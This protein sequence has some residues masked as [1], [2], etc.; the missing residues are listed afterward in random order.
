MVSFLMLIF[1]ICIHCLIFVCLKSQI[2]RHLFRIGKLFVFS[3]DFFSYV[4]L[5]IS[6]FNC[7]CNSNG[8]IAILVTAR[9]R[10]TEWENFNVFADLF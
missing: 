5:L 6:I 1:I 7:S 2:K 10:L 4:L 3:S 8:M 9:H